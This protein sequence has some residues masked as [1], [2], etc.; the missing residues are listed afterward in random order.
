MH[1]PVGSPLNYT[2]GKLRLL[3]QIA[4]L[5]PADTDT[6]HDVFCGGGNLLANVPARAFTARDIQPD[7]MRTIRWL[8]LIH[9]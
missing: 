1:K 5:L 2:G 4:P 3:P 7:V 8:S 6:L 9:I